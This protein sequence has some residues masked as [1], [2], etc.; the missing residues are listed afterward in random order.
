MYV[1]SPNMDEATRKQAHNN[2]NKNNKFESDPNAQ[3]AFFKE[4]QFF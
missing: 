4:K 3:T 1:P 2:N